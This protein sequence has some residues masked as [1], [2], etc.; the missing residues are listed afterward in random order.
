MELFEVVYLK[1]ADDFLTSLPIKVRAKIFY[2]IDKA[3]LFRDAELFKKLKNTEIW[4]FRTLFQG[5]SYRLF[6]FWDEKRKKVVICTHGMIKKTNK[7]P[8]Q[9]IEKAEH[10]RKMYL[11]K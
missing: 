10:L 3:R 7:T 9:E 6:A 4:E 5:M 1:E 2:N 8:L 11:N